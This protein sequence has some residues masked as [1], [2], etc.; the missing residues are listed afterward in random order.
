MNKYNCKEHLGIL[1]LLLVAAFTL[2]GLHF[3]DW[4]TQ[5][6]SR[7]NQ[8]NEWTKTAEIYIE[9]KKSQKVTK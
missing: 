8:K 7:V 4:P 9:E 3:N 1:L 2:A 5:N 6:L